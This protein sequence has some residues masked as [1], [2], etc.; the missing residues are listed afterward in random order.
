M[1][2]PEIGPALGQTVFEDVAVGHDAALVRF[3]PF[4][5]AH[6][7]RWS[8][9][10]ENWHKIHYDLP[11]ATGHDKLP[12]LLVN[13]SL[14]QQLIA[15]MLKDWA[16]PAGWLWKVCF[17]FRAMNLA[18]EQ[19]EIWAR[20]T[21]TSRTPAFGLVLMEIGIRNEAGL[22]STPGSA[23]VALPFRGGPPVPYPFIPPQETAHDADP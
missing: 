22:E 9:A 7:M 2:M 12:G 1:N 13:G 16:G 14:K 3:G 8:A 5:T 17:Q 15:Q 20:V 21:E 19:L 11:F 10:M 23:T 6:L 18:G 4:T